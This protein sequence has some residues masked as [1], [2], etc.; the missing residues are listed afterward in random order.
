M[1]AEN[2]RFLVIT[3]ILLFSAVIIFRIESGQKK[4]Q[5]VEESID[6]PTELGDW[7][8][9]EI[10][11]STRTLELLETPLVILRKFTNSQGEAVYFSGVFASRS[12]KAIH[13]P[14]ICLTGGGVAARKDILD[15]EINGK[16]Y[17]T[18][19]LVI[20]PGKTRRPKEVIF[21]WYRVG[22]SLF[23]NFYAQQSQMTWMRIHRK[24]LKS[25]DVALLRISTR[26]KNEKEG[27]AEM[28][29]RLK[30][31]AEV[32]FNYLKL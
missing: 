15:L 19:K 27:E 30:A 26:Q 2:K 21:Y 17:P 22:D 24:P 1:G 5:V 18:N 25:S 4:L 3:A 20:L 28:E 16:N 14:E 7:V 9:E 8:G 6:F 12:R 11:V 13:P 32:L 31:F 10:P 23:S 29:L